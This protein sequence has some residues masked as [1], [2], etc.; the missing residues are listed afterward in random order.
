MVSSNWST[1]L[2]IYHD[3]NSSTNYTTQCLFDIT[4]FL[5]YAG[6]LTV[7]LGLIGNCLSIV[8]F[9]RKVLRSRSCS[10][11]FLALSVSDMCVLIGYTIENLLFY[12]YGIQLL[13]NIFMCK[14]VIFLIYA[15]TDISNY[16][17]TLAA[18]DRCILVSHRTAHYRF[19]R[20]PIAKIFIVI[21]VILFSLINSHFLYGFRVDSTGACL[22]AATE[23]VNFYVHH[24]DSYID[25][26]KTVLIPF[27]IIFICNIFII[28]RLTRKQ[29]FL[30]RTASTRRRRRRL[31]KDRQ[32]TGFLLL[33]SILF[34]ILS[35]PSE[36]NDFLRTSFTHQF[37]IEYACQLWISTTIFIFLHQL[38]HASHFYVYTLSGPIFRQEF[39]RFLCQYQHHRHPPSS[40]QKSNFFEHS[41]GQS[42]TSRF[43]H[44]DDGDEQ[45]LSFFLK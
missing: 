23:Y 25:I 30:S 19:C 12:G 33:T 39:H 1:T 11:Y 22:P 29:S 34:I 16:F 42:A 17:L 45:R 41:H 18:I 10:M 5:R 32:L 2:I 43:M 9:S 21:V 27:L 35:L 15:S 4:A 14:I 36:I 31:E 3:R 40:H 8:I 24:Y 6:T 20:K 37:Q 7:I 28:I 44:H 13:S 26:I 38:N